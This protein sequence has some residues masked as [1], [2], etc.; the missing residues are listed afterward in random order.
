MLFS[1]TD[2]FVETDN[3]TKISYKNY[4]FYYCGLFFIRGKKEGRESIISVAQEYEQTGE[5][6]FKKMF[7]SFACAVRMP[8][9]SA[10]FF[11][12]NSYQNC[13]FIGNHAVSD[14]FLN[15]VRYER[16][17]TFN[18]EALVELMALTLGSVSF[19]KTLVQGIQLS[20]NQC[21]YIC[22]HGLIAKRDKN[23][24]DI[25]EPS[26]IHNVSQFFGDV[27]YALSDHR[28]TLSLTGGYDSRLV[29]AC[30]KKHGHADVFISGNNESDPDIIIAQKTARAGGQELD[31]LKSKKPKIDEA[32]VRELFNHTQGCMLFA[33][34][35][36]MRMNAFLKNK[37]ETGY[38]CYMT[39]DGGIMHKDW[40]WIQDFPFFKLK[41]TNL[42]RFYMQRIAKLKKNV[43]FGEKLLSIYNDLDNRYI[44]TIQQYSKPYNTQT[45]DSLY[46]RIHGPKNAIQYNIQSKTIPSYAPLW[47]LEMVRYSYHLKR[48]KRFFNNFMREVITENAPAIAKIRT[49]YGTTASSRP[50]F[51]IGDFFFQA[52]NYLVRALRLLGRKFLNQQLF[53]GNPVTWSAQDE[54]RALPISAKALAFCT[55]QGFIRPDIT[56]DSVSYDLLERMMQIYLLAETMGISDGTGY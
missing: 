13:F 45:Y 39:G 51:I 2:G 12:D 50:L 7:G 9:E 28:I 35:A 44:K 17:D 33:N 46:F 19:G 40:W 30:F 49:V 26:S 20:C 38:T 4:T 36:F 31:I 37:K 25:D 5:W 32:Y 22:S 41:K 15:L 8:D 14:N 43:P 11:A 27:A 54:I 52:E 18:K 1:I 34:D 3:F 23:I 6:P 16:A 21:Y 48:N 47:E 29:F 56:I 10:V 24:G 42:K 55:A 53:I